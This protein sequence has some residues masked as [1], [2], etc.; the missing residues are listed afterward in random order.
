MVQAWAAI[1]GSHRQLK[2]GTEVPG[3][4]RAPCGG[5]L[6]PKDRPRRRARVGGPSHWRRWTALANLHSACLWRVNP[7]P[8]RPSHRTTRRKCVNRATRTVPA[9]HQ[10]TRSSLVSGP[11]AVSWRHLNGRAQPAPLATRILYNAP[12]GEKQLLHVGSSS[13]SANPSH[14]RGPWAED[15]RDRPY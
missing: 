13:L 5:L 3:M 10:T 4:R 8:A 12:R 1:R 2:A 15:T 6:P 9:A 7:K 14:L 11:A